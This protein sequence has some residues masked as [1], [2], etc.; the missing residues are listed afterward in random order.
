MSQVIAALTPQ[1][2]TAVAQALAALETQAPQSSR[3]NTNYGSGLP[4]SPG[5][6]LSFGLSSAAGPGLYLTKG[7]GISS[8]VGSGISSNGVPG[9]SSNVSSGSAVASSNFG[10]VPTSST[11]SAISFTQQSYQTPV[12]EGGA[13]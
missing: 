13:R 8:I 6:G 2:Q 4:T 7:L 12:T 5:A 1:I 3:G 11:A 10:Q 9:L